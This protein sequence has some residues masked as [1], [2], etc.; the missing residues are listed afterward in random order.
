MLSSSLPKNNV[1]SRPST[2][3]D[4]VPPVWYFHFKL[5]AGAVAFPIVLIAYMLLTG[6]L[7]AMYKTVSTPRMPMDW[8]IAPVGNFQF[9]VPGGELLLPKVFKAYT[10]LS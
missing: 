5:P 10:L 9:K 8:T 6:D 4:T 7:Q 3:G 1:P 2:P